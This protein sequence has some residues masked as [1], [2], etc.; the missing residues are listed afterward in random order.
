MWEILKGK[1]HVVSRNNKYACIY[2]PYHFMGLE[3]P[4]SILLGD[5]LK[6][7]THPEC[8]QISVMSGVASKN[9][10]KGETLKVEGHH[11]SIEGLIPQLLEK[12]IAEEVAPFYLLNGAELLNNID[13]GRPIKLE[14]V[15]LQ[16]IS[17]YDIY[18]KGLEIN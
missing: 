18:K 13:I 12:K 14:D 2:L 17:I 8:R 5:L 9:F 1:G 4:I 11:H 7:G 3:S 10:K 6:I 16:D 15:K